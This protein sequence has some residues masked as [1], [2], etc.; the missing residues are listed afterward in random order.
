MH[1]EVQRGRIAAP[2]RRVAQND[3]KLP[4]AIE[5]PVLLANRSKE[6]GVVGSEPDGALRGVGPRSAELSEIDGV[7]ADVRVDD[8]LEARVAEL[9]HHV[10]D[11]VSK[12][13]I[14][15]ELPKE[16]VLLRPLMHLAHQDDALASSA[17]DTTA[18]TAGR[19]RTPSA[20]RRARLQTTTATTVP[21][22]TATTDFQ[23]ET[24]YF[25]AQSYTKTGSATVLRRRALRP[26]GRT[27]QRL[28]GPVSA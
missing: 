9:D 12:G 15:H 11:N 3:A 26:S 14:A 24:R 2:D 8:R 19:K 28:I 18:S 13:G 25:G 17:A 4:T 6:G 22:R 10:V 7:A 27:A 5:S 23:R 20:S 21:A 16:P 1:P